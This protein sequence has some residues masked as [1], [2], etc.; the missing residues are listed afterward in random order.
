MSWWLTDRAQ[1]E[2]ELIRLSYAELLYRWGQHV[3]RAHVLELCRSAVKPS[4]RNQ[5]A[6]ARLR[7][8]NGLGPT[9]TIGASHVLPLVCL[10]VGSRD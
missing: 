4:E 9:A 2:L 8:A 6:V 1:L 3:E 7:E 5:V 10:H